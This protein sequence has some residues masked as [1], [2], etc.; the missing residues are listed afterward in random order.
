MCHVV[1]AK[2]AHPHSGLGSCFCVLALDIFCLK[3]GMEWPCPM[4]SEVLRCCVQARL[5]SK[6][7]IE[8]HFVCFYGTGDRVWCAWFD[9]KMLD[10]SSTMNCVFFWVAYITCAKHC[11]RWEK[12]SEREWESKALVFWVWKKVFSRVIGSEM[13]IFIKCIPHASTWYIL[14]RIIDIKRPYLSIIRVFPSHFFLLFISHHTQSHR[15][16]HT[17]HSQPIAFSKIRWE[18]WENRA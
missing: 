3:N 4:N 6:N 14:L 5:L 18:K 16:I 12:Q 10:K 8:Q 1:H 9:G 13:S 7:R 17:P 15:H 2:Q 11:L